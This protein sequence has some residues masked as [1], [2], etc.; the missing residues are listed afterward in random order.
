MNIDL[1]ILSDG[2]RLIGGAS[3]PDDPRGVVL[4]L[5]GIPSVAPSEPGDTGYPGLAGSFAERGWLAGWID[6]R[7]VRDSGGYFSI[8]GWVRD[9]RAAS[10]A[11]GAL[12]A[13]HGL[14]RAIVA[15]SAGGA[16]ATHAIQ[17]GLPADALALLAAPATW[18][19]FAGAPEEGVQR[20]TEGAG[21]ALAPEVHQDPTEWAAEFQTV[22]T[23]SAIGELKIPVLIVH[24]TSDIVV[25]VD[26]AS[27]IH[28]Q[29]PDA[30]LHI[31]EGAGHQL[32]RDPDAMD[33]VFGWLDK[34]VV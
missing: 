16:V 28:E 31:L 26:H 13:A 29:A 25:P 2:N 9:A 32:R 20:I 15:S 6:M 1:E 22:A 34:V 8:E 5:H 18:V 14:P 10:D 30:E 3:I 27:R 17:R 24:G 4:L 19:S 21:M 33:I 11:L 23:A 12:E 7:A